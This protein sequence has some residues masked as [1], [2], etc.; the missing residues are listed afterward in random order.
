MADRRCAGASHR[1]TRALMMCASWTSWLRPLVPPLAIDLL[2]R[3]T[4]SLQFTGAYASWEEAR[5]RSTGYDAAAIRDVVLAAARAAREGRAAFERD[6]VA[7]A[8]PEFV[9][10]VATA[11]LR[12]AAQAGGRLR[13]LDFGGSLG[14]FYFQHR[15]LL[16][17]LEVRWAVVEQPG[18]VEAGN[19]EFANETLSFHPNIEA[20]V[21]AATP[22]V[23]LFSSVLNYLEQPHAV[24]GE[25]VRRRI[26]AVI[27]DRTAVT[28]AERDRL[29][30]QHSPGH[31]YDATYPAWLLS[32]TGVT[33]HFA[34]DYE[35]VAAFESPE[36]VAG[37]EFA[38]FYF[39]RKR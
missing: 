13:V 3:R 6:G 2:R 30:I 12:E 32:R 10:P 36:R 19:R 17:G 4:P 1:S 25:V 35:Q 15:R 29:T 39:A 8:K 11:L 14:S 34:A 20:A 7:F 26:G 38:G 37:V 5:A 33:R 22:S 28:N 23:A 24:I 27:I 16:R 21:E 9:W 18:F 31:V